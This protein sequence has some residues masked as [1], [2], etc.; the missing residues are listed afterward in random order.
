MNSR[1]SEE[2][3][4]TLENFYVC[5][6]DTQVTKEQKAEHI[7]FFFYCICTYLVG[8]STKDDNYGAST[9]KHAHLPSSIS[10]FAGSIRASVVHLD[11]C[12]LYPEIRTIFVAV[13]S[14]F[15]AELKNKDHY[16]TTAYLRGM[17]MDLMGRLP[18]RQQ[19]TV[20]YRLKAIIWDATKISFNLL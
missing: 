3:N 13:L 14:H 16:H 6:L 4:S 20:G 1:L 10:R 19:P 5:C 9:W 12:E 7:A 17:L 18:I 2:I 15:L 8:C 11:A